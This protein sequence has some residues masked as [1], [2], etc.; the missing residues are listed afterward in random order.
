LFSGKAAPSDQLAKQIVKLINAVA[1]IVNGDQAMAGKMKVVFLPD[2]DVSLAERIV[3]ATDLSEQIATPGQEACGTSNMKFALNGAITIASKG[4]SNIELI[5]RIGEDNIIV[6]GKGIEELPD[7][8]RYQPFDL[9]SSNKHLSSIFALL[10]ERL[11]RLPQNGLSIN[12]LVST[13][14]DS[15]R[16]F[17]LFDFDDYILKQ[18]TADALFLDAKAWLS[19]GV[20]AIARS[21]WFSIDRTVMEYVKEIWGVGSRL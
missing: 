10:E 20:L 7:P 17:V 8:R 2:Y 16:F 19:K 5:K 15:D 3:A 12:P 4:G 21:G 11:A 1:D 18:N 13:L 14:K 9:I 6:F